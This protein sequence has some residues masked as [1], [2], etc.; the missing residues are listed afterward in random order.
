[1]RDDGRRPQM[2]G[3]RAV[4]FLAVFWYHA[5]PERCPWGYAGVYVFFALSGFLIGGILGR[6]LPGDIPRFYARRALRLCPAYFLTLA[7]VAA[8]EGLPGW[9]WYATY[10]ANVPVVLRRSWPAAPA[11]HLWSLA[12]EFWWYMLAPIAMIAT[13]R[14][15]RPALILALLVAAKAGRVACLRAIPGPWGLY[16]MPAGAE[17]ILWGGLMAEMPRLT[18][19]RAGLAACSGLALLCGWIGWRC[20]VGGES[21]YS[22]STAFLVLGGTPDGLG[23]ALLVYGLWWGARGLA[24]PL[25]LAPLAYLGTISYG[26]YL[27][28]LPA[29]RWTPPVGGYGPGLWR[30]GPHLPLIATVA[31]AALSWHLVER[32]I[33]RIG[34]R[35]PPAA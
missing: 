30:L 8:V 16:L 34:R 15:R 25:S 20:R 9:G 22:P 12:V 27:Y 24:R 10:N 29:L 2:D 3:L 5:D 19:G 31:A 18:P 14:R 26:L 35:R 1:M 11:A 7:A 33:M 6:S 4:C 21:G 23:S 28:H 17:Y 13:P 32:P